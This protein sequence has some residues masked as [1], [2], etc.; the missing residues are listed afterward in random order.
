[1]SESDYAVLGNAPGESFSSSGSSS[2]SAIGPSGLTAVCGECKTAVTYEHLAQ[3][4]VCH[5]CGAV[6]MVQQNNACCTCLSNTCDKILDACV[7]S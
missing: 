6:V 3:H 5:N 1:M 2:S 7:I 4:G